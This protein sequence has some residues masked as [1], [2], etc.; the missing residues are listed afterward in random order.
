MP[1]PSPEAPAPI[2]S[3]AQALVGY[4]IDLDD[5]QGGALVVLD[6][7]PRHL[8]RVGSLHGG[9][10]AMLLDAAAGFA[11]SRS[12]SQAGDACLVTLSLT[13][14]F[15]A[16]TGS[17]RVVAQGRIAGGGETIRFAEAALRDQSGRVL[18]TACGAFKRVRDRRRP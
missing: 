8:N 9:I 5:P 12:W 14:N 2:D 18:A 13:T 11:A 16:S 1:S 4:A 3:G 7:E 6:I 17:G 15:L 10:V